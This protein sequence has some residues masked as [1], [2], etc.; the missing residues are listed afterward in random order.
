MQTQEAGN[1]GKVQ[2]HSRTIWRE[3]SLDPDTTLYF[4]EKYSGEQAEDKCQAIFVSTIEAPFFE[5][6][7]KSGR[8]RI[9]INKLRFLNLE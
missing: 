2:D 1:Q 7:A 4:R 3:L 6:R 5:E 8:T 9:T